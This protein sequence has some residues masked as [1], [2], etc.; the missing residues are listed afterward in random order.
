[1]PASPSNIEKVESSSSWMSGCGTRSSFEILYLCLSTIL[2]C[3]WSAFHDDIPRT[4][5]EN[6]RSVS[7]AFDSL[8]WVV[9]FLLFPEMLP[10]AALEQLREAYII[11]KNMEY[12]HYQVSPLISTF[13]PR[14]L[15]RLGHAYMDIHPFLLRRC[16]RLRI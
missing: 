6:R 13:I 7:T 3:G 8:T 4:R 5:P 10:S 12:I 15:I 16:R 9:E 14:L 1:M 2:I 11:S